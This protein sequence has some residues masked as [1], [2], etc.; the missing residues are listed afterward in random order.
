MSSLSWSP[1]K[2][3]WT[4]GLSL[5]PIFRAQFLTVNGHSL[6]HEKGII[7]W[8]SDQ[9]LQVHLFSHLFLSLISVSFVEKVNP[10]C[11]QVNL[12]FVLHMMN[13]NYYAGNPY[14]FYGAK[15]IL[16]PR[17]LPYTIATST[18][19]SPPPPLGHWW[20]RRPWPF[21]SL[22]KLY[23][24]TQAA[25]PAAARRKEDCANVLLA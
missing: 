14:L 20:R 13:K 11:L 3:T 9:T 19:S 21:W 23:R 10:W 24:A 4:L 5:S 12:F 16:P 8:S 1:A 25:R 2:P 18:M 22:G 17:I 6:G 7:L 15:V